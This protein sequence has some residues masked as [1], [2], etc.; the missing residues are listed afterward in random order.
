MLKILYS[1]SLKGKVKNNNQDA[2]LVKPFANGDMLL[3]V[4]DGMGGGVM[5]AELADSAIKILDTFFYEPTNYP[6]QKLKRVLFVINDKLNE[7][8]DG[9]KGGQ[10]YLCLL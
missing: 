8:L 1:D 9:Q 3:A 6:L 10:L 5:G 2:Y 4:A 7:M